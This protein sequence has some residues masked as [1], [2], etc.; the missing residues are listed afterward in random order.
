MRLA[1]DPLVV[2]GGRIAIDDY[3]HAGFPGV[4]RAVDEFRGQAGDRG[5]LIDD[6]FWRKSPCGPER[7]T[8]AT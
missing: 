4:K 1:L 7:E 2:S 8:S 5:Q 6:H 3:G